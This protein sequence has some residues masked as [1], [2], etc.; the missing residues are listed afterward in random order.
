MI[1]AWADQVL[2]NVENGTLPATTCMYQL[3]DFALTGSDVSFAL[4]SIGSNIEG[5]YDFIS[6]VISPEGQKICLEQMKAIPVISAD[7]IDSD[8]KDLVSSLG[9]Y[10]YISTGTLWSDHL[11]PTWMENI[12]AL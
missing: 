10:N 9:S 3:D 8:K 2:T 6:F 11:Y 1:P 5:A 7:L 12:L 4:P